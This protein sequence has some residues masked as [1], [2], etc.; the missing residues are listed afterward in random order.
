MNLKELAR[1]CG[2]DASTVS[3]A[4]KNDPRI[5]DSTVEKVQAAA[6]KHGYQ[7][8]IAARMLK[9]GNSHIFWMLVPALGTPVDWKIAER[10]SS[11]AAKRDYETAI[12]VHRGSQ[13]DFDRIIR[14]ISSGLAAGAIINRRDIR[15]IAS[16]KT[17]IELGFPVVF[18]DVPVYSLDLGVVTTDHRGASIDLVEA[19]RTAGADQFLFLFD[20]RFNRV[21]EIRYEGAVRAISR[22]GLRGLFVAEDPEWREHLASDGTLAILGASQQCIE[23]FYSE[24]EAALGGRDIVVGCFDEWRGSIHPFRECSVAVQD[25][26]GMADAALDHLFALIERKE[27]QKNLALPISELRR[28]ENGNG[29]V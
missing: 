16:V 27:P 25:Y 24:N 2:V 4:L 28:I 7:P 1:L 19:S 15:N 5:S 6:A 23:T 10:A 11:S 12:T 3:R 17:L 29:P 14:N 20:R 21:E 22:Q 18:V 9:E 13:E 26:N 8:N